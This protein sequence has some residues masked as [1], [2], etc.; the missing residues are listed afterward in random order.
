MA[1]DQVSRS[2]PPCSA[3]PRMNDPGKSFY[4]SAPHFPQLLNRDNEAHV[5]GYWRLKENVAGGIAQQ[6]ARRREE[7]QPPPPREFCFQGAA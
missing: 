4:V 3:L 6:S 5:P 1:L 2:V 7:V